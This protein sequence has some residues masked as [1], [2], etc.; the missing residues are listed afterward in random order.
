MDTQA[1]ADDGAT[2]GVGDVEDVV[3]ATAATKDA[4]SRTLP[5]S[6]MHPSG[7]LLR[8]SCQA[9][10]AWVIRASGDTG[11]RLSEQFLT[12]R[13][14]PQSWSSVAARDGACPGSLSFADGKRALT[15]PLV[16]VT[17]S[18]V[19]D[20]QIAFDPLAAAWSL[21]CPDPELDQAR[22]VGGPSEG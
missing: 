21:P 9:P 20:R 19:Q 15:R 7:P 2:E 17:E 8:E 4:V 16:H 3:H 13:G 5:F 1:P 22:K 11:F 10:R 6:K 12:A 14:G 18:G